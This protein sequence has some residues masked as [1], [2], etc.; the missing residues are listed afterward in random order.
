MEIRITTCPDCGEELDWHFDPLT[1]GGLCHKC[2][3]IFYPM[4][5]EDIDED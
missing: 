4:D 5:S 1:D 3:N 2:G